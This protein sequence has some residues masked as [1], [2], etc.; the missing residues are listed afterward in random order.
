[1]SSAPQQPIRRPATPNS[2]LDEAVRFLDRRFEDEHSA[3]IWGPF[4]P[5]TGAHLFGPDGIPE[6]VWPG[7]PSPGLSPTPM[8]E[9][10]MW[11]WGQADEDQ[12]LYSTGDE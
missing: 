9:I 5:W 3:G 11:G 1:M 8:D 7:P 2:F 12:L 10:M 4:D 6:I